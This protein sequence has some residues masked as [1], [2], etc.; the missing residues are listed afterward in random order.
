MLDNEL[1]IDGEVVRDDVSTTDENT[2]DDS[3]QDTETDV[4]TSH[5]EQEENNGNDAESEEA[6]DEPESQEADEEYSLQIGEE[7][8]SLAE[9]ED[10]DDIDG[11]PAPQWVKELRKNFKQ[12]QKENRELKRQQESPAESP[13][14]QEV[15]QAEALP[16]K[17]TLESCDYDEEVF[18]KALTDWHE[19]KSRVEQQNQAKEDQQKQFQQR[20]NDRL[21]QHRERAKKLP[22]KDYAEMEAIVQSEL[23]VLHQEI[24]IHAADEGS[25]LIA[26]GLGKNE[27]LRQRLSAETDPIRAA[28]MMGQLSRDVRLAPKPKKSPKPEPEVRGGGGNAKSD[29]FQKQCPGAKIE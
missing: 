13:A 15:H 19:K 25:E 29:D 12:L 6:E 11:K 14:Q 2:V 9:E 17:P 21:D 20:F 27:K 24:L 23:P 28:Y 10:E 1:I 22:V 7:E 18:E 26:Y 8:I 4:T 16:S 3:H 5:E